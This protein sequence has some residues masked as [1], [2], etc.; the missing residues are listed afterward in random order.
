MTTASEKKTPLE[1]HI[2]KV[3]KE[4]QKQGVNIVEV[5]YKDRVRIHANLPPQKKK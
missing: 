5:G 1:E 3:L 4:A 2:E